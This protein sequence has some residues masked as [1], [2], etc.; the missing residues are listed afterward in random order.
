V[1]N[2][3]VVGEAAQQ[4]AEGHFAAAR[5][6]FGAERIKVEHDA[7]PNHGLRRSLWVRWGMRRLDVG[8]VVAPILRTVVPALVVAVLP[9]VVL[10]RA[11]AVLAPHSAPRA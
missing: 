11:A 1:H 6:R 9:W 8:S 4:L 7:N 3:A 5:A 10:M 2:R